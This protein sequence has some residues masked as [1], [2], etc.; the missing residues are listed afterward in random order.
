MLK[1][2]NN[3]KRRLPMTSYEEQLQILSTHYTTINNML[4][5]YSLQPVEYINAIQ[6]L[7]AITQEIRTIKH[8][9][10]Y[11]QTKQDL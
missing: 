6:A 9:I 1:H 4:T 2:L 10:K 7:L 5:E 3:K 11:S 8:V